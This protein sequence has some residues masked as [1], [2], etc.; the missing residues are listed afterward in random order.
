VVHHRQHRQQEDGARKTI[1]G[2]TGSCCEIS[3]NARAGLQ[4]SRIYMQ[5]AVA[6]AHDIYM[7]GII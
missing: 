3:L 4:A 6:M 1:V 2:I 7:E 5:Q